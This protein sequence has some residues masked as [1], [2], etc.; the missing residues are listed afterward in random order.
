MS[1]ATHLER[2][3]EPPPFLEHSQWPLFGNVCGRRL[4]L[5]LKKDTGH[6]HRA[7]ACASSCLPR[8]LSVFERCTLGWQAKGRF[9]PCPHER[10][11]R[12]AADV[13]YRERSRQ[14][15]SGAAPRQCGGNSTEHKLKLTAPQG[16]RRECDG[17]RRPEKK[18]SPSTGVERLHELWN[19]LDRRNGQ[20]DVCTFARA[21]IGLGGQASVRRER[22]LL[23]HRREGA[24]WLVCTG[25]LGSQVR[26][27]D[28]PKG[29]ES[30]GMRHRV[31]TSAGHLGEDWVD[32]VLSS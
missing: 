4:R 19:A 28:L 26:A 24:W 31:G 2:G 18:L 20:R 7:G 14:R 12:L 17:S 27:C 23:V 10:E 32:K 1:G 15:P 5:P 30:V 16:E 21:P 8:Y 6:E 11:T 13:R 29:P 3:S 25:L 22:S 9:D